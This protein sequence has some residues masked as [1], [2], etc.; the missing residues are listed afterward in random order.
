MESGH[1]ASRASADF[2]DENTS[3]KAAEAREAPSALQRQLMKEAISAVHEAVRDRGIAVF[4]THAYH[5]PQWLVRAVDDL[6]PECPA[7]GNHIVI[8][9]RPVEPGHWL[10]LELDVTGDGGVAT[11]I[12]N[13]PAAKTSGYSTGHR[14]GFL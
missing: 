6:I 4:H 11:T 14:K 13:P 5:T 3:R 2:T 10:K 1:G 7:Y 9:D 8:L 12:S